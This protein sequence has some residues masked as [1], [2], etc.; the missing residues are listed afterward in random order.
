MQDTKETVNN[1]AYLNS[2]DCPICGKHISRGYE[3]N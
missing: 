3:D 1:D 2:C